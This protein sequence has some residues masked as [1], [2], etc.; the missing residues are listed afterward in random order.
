MSS[1]HYGRPPAAIS[2]WVVNGFKLLVRL[3]ALV[4]FPIGLAFGAYVVFFGTGL[5][6]ASGA[7][8]DGGTVSILALGGLLAG[9]FGVL[10]MVIC[11]VGLA[12]MV[13]LLFARAAWLR[14]LLNALLIGM[15]AVTVPPALLLWSES[16]A[17]EAAEAET[18]QAAASGDSPSQIELAD[19]YYK[20]WQYSSPEDVQA[21]REALYWYQEAAYRGSNFG[22]QGIGSC[23]Q[24]CVHG[25]QV[26]RDSLTYVWYRVLAAEP[27]QLWQYAMLIDSFLKHTELGDEEIAAAEAYALPVIEVLGD[28]RMT[29]AERKAAVEQ[30]LKPLVDQLELPPRVDS[31]VGDF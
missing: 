8:R 3:L 17:R 9:G 13:G 1:N 2:S 23:Y 15:L 12:S 27:D 29:A 19:R 24:N 11:G 7:N 20:R 25:D 16:G 22:R 31:G 28:G 6:E 26:V 5:F 14:G 21:C 18:E 4:V 30:I 10:V